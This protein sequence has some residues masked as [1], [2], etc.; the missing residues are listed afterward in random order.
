MYETANL[1]TP[2]SGRCALP[3]DST[4]IS[5]LP[6]WDSLLVL[7]VLS[8]KASSDS[9]ANY[10]SPATP[11]SFTTTTTYTHHSRSLTP[12]SPLIH[13]SPCS[14]SDC[15]PSD[16]YKQPGANNTRSPRQQSERATQQSLHLPRLIRTRFP[17]PKQISSCE[18]LTTPSIGNVSPRPTVIIRDKHRHAILLQRSS[19]LRCHRFGRSLLLRLYRRQWQLVLQAGQCHHLHWC[20]RIR[21]LQQGHRHG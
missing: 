21:L 9:T 1:G 7:P 2:I 17:R 15:V 14:L 12:N 11:H 18:L 6:P 16:Q 10:L 4:L 3:L 5:A 19:A 13:Q 8:P 20:W